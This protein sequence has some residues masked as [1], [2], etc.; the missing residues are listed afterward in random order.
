M[1]SGKT[2]AEEIRA[3]TGRVAR[4]LPS[5]L[6]FTRRTAGTVPIGPENV[7]NPDVI[8]VLKHGD[9]NDDQLYLDQ[10][11]STATGVNPFTRIGRI[12]DNKMRQFITLYDTSDYYYEGQMTHYKHTGSQPRVDPATAV[13]QAEYAYT[14]PAPLSEV[15][16]ATSNPK[17]PRTVGAGFIIDQ[18]QTKGKL[19]IVFRDGTYYNYYEVPLTTWETFKSLPSKGAFIRSTL[20]GFRRGPASDANIDPM[21]RQELYKILRTSQQIAKGRPMTKRQQQTKTL[22]SSP[23][24]SN[25]TPKNSY[26]LQRARR[27]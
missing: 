15:P 3:R 11:V 8:D 2:L 18:G 21:V 25:P 24:H 9:F 19:T 20:D 13:D 14:S 5:N 27:P 7:I 17:K 16:T 26:R 22:A 4:A 10:R 1:P 6:R 23:K 12:T